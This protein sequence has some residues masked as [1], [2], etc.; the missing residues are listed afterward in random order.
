MQLDTNN[1]YNDLYNQNNGLKHLSD[2]FYANGIV[3]REPSN[4]S[5]IY[6]HYDNGWYPISGNE[7]DHPCKGYGGIM[8]TFHATGSNYVYIKLLILIN[9]FTYIMSQDNSGKILSAFQRLSLV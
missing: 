3:Y 1:Y 6:S 2:K 9:C 5:L 8:I 7:P 4:T